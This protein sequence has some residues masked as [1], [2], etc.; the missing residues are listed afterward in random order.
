M[1]RRRLLA[2][3]LIAFWPAGCL[4]APGGRAVLPALPAEGPAEQAERPP[5]AS[6]SPYHPHAVEPP[7]P[8]A[9]EHAALPEPKPAPPPPAPTVAEPVTTSAAAP[10]QAPPPDPALVAALRAV[11]ERRDADVQEALRGLKDD[12]TRQVVLGLLNTAACLEGGLDRLSPDDARVLL[13]KVERAHADLRARAP[14]SLHNLCFF[15]RIYSFNHV[16]ALPALPAFQAGTDDRPGERVKVYVEVRNFRC[17]PRGPE[18]PYVIA[19]SGRVRLTEHRKG[20][21]PREETPNIV[22]PMDF[23]AVPDVSRNP[24]QDYFI[25]F[26]FHVPPQ[27]P[28]GLYTLKVEIK[29]ETPL[30][31]GEPPRK[32]EPV[33]ID[34]RVIGPGATPTR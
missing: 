8:E 31:K 18:G 22:A 5:E 4:F 14:L 9:I 21:D 20:T 28:P 32:A 24:R 2:V 6:P 10:T 17:L 23:P 27:V 15:R 13:A 25:T 19:L 29:D 34:F 3:A 1:R 16:D 33:E 12:E 11:L 26:E 30:K 7:P